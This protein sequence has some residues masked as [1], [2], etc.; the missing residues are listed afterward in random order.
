MN[1]YQY[2]K[3]KEKLD[4]DLLEY[5]KMIKK[6]NEL[7]ESKKG[8]LEVFNSLCMEYYRALI[9]SALIEFKNALD[10]DILELN[11]TL[12]DEIL[13]LSLII[14]DVKENKYD[15]K[16]DMKTFLNYLISITKENDYIDFEPIFSGGKKY[17][18]DSI[19]KYENEL[20]KINKILK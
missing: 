14:I 8:D 7:A 19:K 16:V 12:T 9:I 15:S 11:K 1:L 3:M 17:V 2:E 6:I 10:Y 20:R 5:N 18:D 13:R 4:T